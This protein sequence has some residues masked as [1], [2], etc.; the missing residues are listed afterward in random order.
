LQVKEAAS[1]GPLTSREAAATATVL[2]AVP[3]APDIR[4]LR[5]LSAIIFTLNTR[6]ELEGEVVMIQRVCTMYCVHALWAGLGSPHPGF[7]LLPPAAGS[8]MGLGSRKSD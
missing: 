7:Q 8:P 5:V 1:V 3:K 6:A 4:T 2:A